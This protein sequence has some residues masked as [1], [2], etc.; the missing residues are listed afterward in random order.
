MSVRNKLQQISA[1]VEGLKRIRDR[2]EGYYYGVKY[3][4]NH[5]SDFHGIV[6]VIGEL[7]SF[8]AELEAALSTALGGG[9]Q[10]L[11]TIDQ[12]SARDAINL[13]KQT[14]SGELPFTSRWLTS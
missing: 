14:R 11:V 13:L 2:H 8:P 4:L 1:Q 5:R 9:V 7:I 6:G 12:N 3:V 10:D